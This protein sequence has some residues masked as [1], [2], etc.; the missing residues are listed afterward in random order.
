MNL[1][2][3]LITPSYN[4]GRY[5]KDTIESILN[6]NYNN[7][8]H[9]VIDGGST[10]NTLDILKKY[11]HIKWISEPD[12]GPADAINKGFQ[13]ASGDVFAWINSDDYYEKNIFHKVESSFKNDDNIQIL[14]GNT[15][16][17][18]QYGE[19]LHRDKTINY[20][21]D[22]L[23]RVDPEV[24]RQP[25]TFFR[26]EYLQKKGFLND[27]I[28]VV[29]DLEF[30]IRLLSSTK[31]YLIDEPFAN[32]RIHD[33]TLSRRNFKKHAGEVIKVCLNNGANIFDKS[34]RRFI[35]RYFLLMLNLYK[36]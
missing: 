30:F 13:M 16:M 10:D 9:I 23:V 19:I 22:Y 2:F 14:S 1:K 35:V 18:S 32:Y 5:I 29:F 27:S 36:Y 33:E 21:K 17:V 6:Q 8:E 12:K 31:L 3:S 20:D 25:P 28:D 7:F 26:A 11:S 4:Q 34:V 24:L 15:N